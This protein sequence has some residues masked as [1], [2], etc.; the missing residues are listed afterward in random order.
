[1]N[2]MFC[3]NCD[4]IFTDPTELSFT[5][6]IPH[7]KPCGKECFDFLSFLQEAAWHPQYFNQWLK[8]SQSDEAQKYR[9]D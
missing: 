8:W 3:P 4:K 7:H 2:E 9:V 1:M 6:G 5:E